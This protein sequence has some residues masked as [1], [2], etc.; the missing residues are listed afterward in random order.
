MGKSTVFNMLTGLN[1]HVG[2]WPGKTIEQKTGVVNYKGYKI[3]LVD[4]PGTYSLTANSLEERIA[5]NYLLKNRPDA[6]II[7]LNA[8]TLEHSLYLLTELINLPIPIVVGLNMMDVAKQQGFQIEEN[9]LS[10]ALG[11]TPVIPIVASHNQGLNKLLDA[12]IEV[13][14]HPNQTLSQKYRITPSDYPHQEIQKQITSKIQGK[15]PAIYP[16]DWIALKLLEGDSEITSMV[17]ESAPETWKSI[18]MLLIDHED[19]F[20]DIAGSRYAWIE[21]LVRAAM[22]N[23]RKGTISLTDRLDKIATHPFAG[24]LLLIGISGA[25]FWLTYTLA[26]PIVYWLGNSIISP[27]AL[28]SKSALGNAPFWLQGLIS[29]GIINGAG[30]VLTFLPILFF[31][32]AAMGFLEDIGYLTRAAYVMDRFMHWMGL[33]GRSFMPL[34]LGFGCNVPSIMGTRIIEDRRARILTIMLSPLVPCTGRIAVITF[35]APAFFGK[36]A[37]IAV[38]GLVSLN[39]VILA[40]L[41]ILTNKFIYKGKRTA[42]IMEIPLYHVPNPRTIGLFIWNNLV[43]FTK[44]AGTIILLVAIVMWWLSN[45]PGGN[46]ENSI[47]AQFGHQLAPLGHCLGWQ[48]WRITIALLTSFLAKENTISTLSVL[49]KIEESGNLAANIAS[50]L[51]MPSRLGFLAIQMLFIPCAATVAAIR[52]EAG[53]KWM[54]INILLLLF[55]SF[56]AGAII[57][58]GLTLLGV[59]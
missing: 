11:D 5:R 18:E 26:N 2:N 22:T 34:F 36:S 54:V 51:T 52:K 3:D 49:Y 45:Y 25:V 27:L 47:L 50:S 31:F 42:F 15:L 41:G 59:K 24:L 21:R 48:D 55:I 10:A 35:L 40:S 16:A 37:L 53:T 30:M 56:S 17:K 33:H 20:L 44:R 29:D 32:F 12:A 23:P 43:E 39:L 6:V 28:W 19:T 4:L 9:V 38:W 14:Q 57:Y 13:S 1:Q 58:W 7:I 46:I 8:A